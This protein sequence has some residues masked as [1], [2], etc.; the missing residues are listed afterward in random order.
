MIEIDFPSGKITP[1][2]AGAVPDT[3][4]GLRKAGVHLTAG[5]ISPDQVPATREDP[6]PVVLTGEVDV[7]VDTRAEVDQVL[8]GSWFFGFIQV[9][10]IKQQSA[11]WLGRRPGEG[12]VDLIVFGFPVSN[13]VIALDSD[14]TN[15]PFFDRAPHSGTAR[16]PQPGQ[17]GLVHVSSRLGD[18]PNYRDFLETANSVTKAKNFLH[19]LSFGVEFTSVFVGRDGSGPIQPIAHIQWKIDLAGALRWRAG[20]PRSIKV[21]SIFGIGASIA[22]GPTD[23]SV[24]AIVE[25]PGPPLIKAIAIESWK[26][27]LSNPRMRQESAKRPL[28]VPKDFW[29]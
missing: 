15:Q 11:E 28:L 20:K 8:S 24:R 16:R 26:Q 13:D 17:R 22:G 19:R 9:A 12:S 14:P 1:S 18:H 23:P 21:P 7:H 29:A 6:K 10:R 27:A 2:V 3:T 5:Y 25:K 4:P